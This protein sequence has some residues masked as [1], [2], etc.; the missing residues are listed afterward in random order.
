M[1]SSTPS[2]ADRERWDAKYRRGEHVGLAPSVLL[3]EVADRLPRR[4][5]ALDLAGGAGRHAI[6][7]AQRGLN[8]T[9]VDVSEV[10]LELARQRA[11]EVGV[12][13]NTQQV[14]LQHQPAPAGPWDLI[15]CVHF[16]WRPL[17]ETIPSLLAPGGIFFFLQPT[18]RNLERHARPAAEYLL[19]EQELPSLIREISWLHYEEGWLGE[20]RHEARLLA[21]REPAPEGNA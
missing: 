20:G 18:R 1:T 4:G 19:S 16:L 3:E 17:L 8:V 21:R 13:L 15:V 7:L 2:S 9:L 10:A 6:W 14:D 5:R 12:P 11:S